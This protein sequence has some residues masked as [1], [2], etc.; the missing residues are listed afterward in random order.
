M[1]TSIARSHF[2]G[3]LFVGDMK[4]QVF[5]TPIDRA[6][7]LAARVVVAAEI[8]RQTPGIFERTMTVSS[9]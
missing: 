5:E 6:E 9:T 8:I 1:A 4:H 3:F 7:E 2:N